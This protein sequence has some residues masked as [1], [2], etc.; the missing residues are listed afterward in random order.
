MGV[1]QHPRLAL[2]PAVHQLMDAITREET[3]QAQLVTALALQLYVR[4]KGRFP[5]TLEAL[6][7][8]CLEQIPLDPYGKTGSRLRYDRDSKGAVIW[9]VGPDGINDG[10]KI[11][12]TQ[13]GPR[14]DILIKLDAPPRAVRST[15]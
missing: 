1:K 11:E 12:F 7:P 8:D 3:K 5:E 9:S 13:R 2:M 10:G 14:G 6:L 15:K 4:K